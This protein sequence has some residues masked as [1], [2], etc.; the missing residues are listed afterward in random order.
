MVKSAYLMMVAIIIVF[1]ACH[2]ENRQVEQ[3]MENGVEVIVN[4]PQTAKLKTFELEQEFVIDLSSNELVQRGLADPAAF[5][6]DSEGNIYVWSQ[7]S[8]QDHVF[9]FSSTGTYVTAFGRTGQGP[10]EVQFLANVMFDSNDELMLVDSQQRKLVYF[11]RSGAYLRQRISL[12]RLLLVIPLRDRN[13][14]TGT[15]TSTPG[16]IFNRIILNVCDS[17]F[18]VINEIGP[19]RYY[20]PNAE[21]NFPAVNPTGIIQVSKNNIFFANSEKGYEIECFD[22]RGKLTRV[23]RKDY[24]PVPLSGKNKEALIERYSR[25]PPEIRNKVVYPTVLPPF[26]TGFADEDGR[27]YIMTNEESDVSGQ[28]W[29]DIFDEKGIFIG[30]IRI[31]NYGIYGKSQGFLFTLFRN[32]RLY[33]FRENRDGFKELAVC[34]IQ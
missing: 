14:I 1:V 32:G 29:H 11:D 22:K 3:L 26:Q 23:I 9:K 20:R 10:G 33:H 16:E 34:R 8:N 7:T 28:Y 17:D 4:H 12:M 25:F 19:W 18:N 15:Q 27:L 24:A 6:V 2:K 13:Y 30:R 21:Q 5:D 31:G